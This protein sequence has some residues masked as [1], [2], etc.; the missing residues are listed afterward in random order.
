MFGSSRK[1]GNPFGSFHDIFDSDSSFLFPPKRCENL[2]DFLSKYSKYL[3]KIENLESK[4][5]NIC[6]SCENK[7]NKRC[8]SCLKGLLHIEFIYS[9]KSGNLD[10]LKFILKC[11]RFTT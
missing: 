9:C 4:E 11:Y 10:I 7:P 8:T 2:D 6:L 5:G 1:Y 3:D